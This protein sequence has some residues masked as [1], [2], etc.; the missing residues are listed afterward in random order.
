MR[1]RP[2]QVQSRIP[3]YSFRSLL[4]PKRIRPMETFVLFNLDR[5][6]MLGKRLEL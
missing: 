1:I 2:G 4:L 5:R 6:E 3:P